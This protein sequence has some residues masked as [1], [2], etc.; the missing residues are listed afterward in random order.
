MTTEQPLPV[1]G[2]ADVFPALIADIQAREQRGIATYGRTLQTQNGR[3]ALLD[4]Y[5]E[6]LDAAVYAK[7][8]LMERDE[9]RAEVQRLRVDVASLRCTHRGVGQPLC[10]VCDP[11]TEAE[12][13]PQ[14]AE[15][16]S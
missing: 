11:R 3:D 15:A 14:T 2:H 12:G 16:V 4:L 6:L 9:A 10:R 1:A 7:Q 8:L 13:G 5:D